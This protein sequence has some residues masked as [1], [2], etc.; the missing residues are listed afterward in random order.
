MQRIFAGM[1]IWAFWLSFPA[2]L[3]KWG[4]HIW[5]VVLPTLFL[6]LLLS[7]IL[8]FILPADSELR[9]KIPSEHQGLTDSS[10]TLN[11]GCQKKSGTSG[12]GSHIKTMVGW[13]EDVTTAHHTPSRPVMPMSERQQIA[14]LMQ[15][16]SPSPPGEC[17][18]SS[19]CWSCPVYSCYSWSPVR[20]NLSRL[21]SL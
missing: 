11:I 14:L 13:A 2:L 9:G 5:L 7:T 1:V 15:M 16:S 8:S 10:N 17:T 6:D 12:V 20:V 3:G 21:W 19:S 18:N 4:H